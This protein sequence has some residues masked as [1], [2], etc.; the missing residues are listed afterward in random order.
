MTSAVILAGGLGTRLRS[1]VPDLPKPM[2]PI[3][4]SPFLEHQIC[5]WISQGI[6]HFVISVGYMHQNIINY[7]GSHFEGVSLE[8]V[9]EKSPLGTG[10]GLVLALKKVSQQENFLLLN[11]DTYFKIE[12]KDLINFSVQNDADWCFSLFRTGELGRYLGM[13]IL[14]D[15]Q[16]TSLQADSSSIERLV[17]GGVYL[18]NPHALSAIPILSGSKVSLEQD[19]FPVAMRMGQRFFGKEYENAFIDIGVPDDYYRA[20]SI[21]T[22]RKERS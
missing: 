3:N 22:K 1:V 17:N 7:F 13:S 10:G 8:Y 21:L 6:N 5:Y 12:L 19:I 18:V 9:I 4:G 15:G 16:I 20:S 14:P 11:G 2:A